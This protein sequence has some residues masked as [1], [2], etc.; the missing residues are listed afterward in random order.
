MSPAG[1]LAAAYGRHRYAVL[2]YTLLATLGAAPLLAALHFSTDLLQILLVFSLLAALLGVP[3]Q[4]WRGLLMVVAAIALGL[5]AA[6]TAAVGR[7]LAAGALAVACAIAVL[8]GV[9]ALRF[10]MRTAS[11]DAE[12]LYAAL[13]VYLLAGL[14][15]GV[16]HWSMEQTWPGS[17][18][19]AG[20]R[21]PGAALP[22]SAAMY[23][24]FV[25]LAT[26]GY[27]DIVPRSEMARGVAVLEAI[28]GQL[29]VA[30]LVAKLVGAR[31]SPRRAERGR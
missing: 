3:G 12:H 9:S 2:F 5:R 11:V 1:L 13:S 8:A 16:V 6:P 19:E 24:S 21:G 4:R 25:T 10:A 20:A 15:F 18:A 23:Y 27:G 29:Y 22:L 30:V 28:G 17:L 26:L 31:L 14:L 7:G